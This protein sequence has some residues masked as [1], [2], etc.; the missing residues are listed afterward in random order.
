MVRK[1]PDITKPATHR[2]RAGFLGGASQDDW[3]TELLFKRGSLHTILAG[4]RKD[5][6][7]MLQRL[8]GRPHGGASDDAGW[9]EKDEEEAIMS[10]FGLVWECD[11]GSERERALFARDRKDRRRCRRVVWFLG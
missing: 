10:F 8:A 4:S 2:V 7:D 5:F 1:K 6:E 3:F 9:W 11:A